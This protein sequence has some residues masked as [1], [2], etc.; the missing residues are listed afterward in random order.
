MHPYTT[1]SNERKS[2][3]LYIAVLSI[4]AALILI[5]ITEAIPFA[6]PWWIDGTSVLGFYGLFYTIFNRY[7][8]K[9]RLL[10]IIGLVKVPNLNGTWNGDLSSSFDKQATKKNATIRISQTWTGISIH[11][12]T[13]SSKSHSLIAAIMTK[14]P[15][16]AVLSYE[17]LNEP[18]PNAKD[19]M[20]CH[21]GTCRLTIQSDENILDGQYYSGRDRQNFGTLRFEQV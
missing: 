8:W 5:L 20:H 19:T 11:L 7:L 3:P 21:R 16:G 14:S 6:I 9:S 1:D 18:L 15:I 2:V 12:E 13:D 17:Y 4:V 10:R